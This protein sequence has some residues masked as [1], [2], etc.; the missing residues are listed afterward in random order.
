MT[1]LTGRRLPLK[2]AAVLMT[3]ALVAAACGNDDSTTSTAGDETPA[4]TTEAPAAP[5]PAD[6][7]T[8]APTT[9]APAAPEPADE[10]APEPEPDSAMGPDGLPAIGTPERCEANRAAG[11]LTFMT[12][13]DFAAAA[14][15][16]EVVAAEAEGYFD[17]MCLDVELQAGFAPGNTTS[18]AAGATQ[19]SMAASFGELVRLN[20]NGGTNMIAFSQL[21]HTAVSG[22]VV[23]AGTIGSLA[24]L[25]GK[26]VGIKGDLPAAIEAML[27]SEGILRADITELLLDGFNPVEHLALG[28]DALPVYKSNEPAVLD[29]EGIPFELYDPLDY[30][31]PASFAV[32]VN[33]PD[34]YEK[35]PTVVE[36]FVRADLKGYYFA[37]NNPEAAVAHAFDLINAAGN[38]L[39]LAE[40]HELSRWRVEQSMIQNV[41]PDGFLIG[42]L[43]PE[44]LGAEVDL[45]TSLGVFDEMPDW[46]SMIDTTVVPKLYDDN[47]ELIWIPMN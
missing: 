7:E 8:P 13:F 5:E 22:L 6:E 21:G 16:V 12:G 32:A 10:A 3:A 14:G 37:A 38:P 45:L 23:P 17:E 44:S 20:V 28:I 2:L 36:D 1:F 40:A 29:R 47:G 42:Q 34:F 18:M 31:V 19:L 4:P 11:T 35:H 43:N 30:G 46:E 15:I 25:A 9:E 41:T 26:T 24:D 33:T 27:A 39:Y